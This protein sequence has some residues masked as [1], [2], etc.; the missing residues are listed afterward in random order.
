MPEKPKAW[1]AWSS[2]K[3]SAW[4]L[5]VARQLGE[6][7]IVGMMTTLTDAYNRIAMHGVR[8]DLL[9]A[10]ANAA[11]L[12]LHRVWIPSPCSD[13][14]YEAAMLEALTLA[15]SQGV[16]HIIFGD[17]FLQDLRDYREQKLAQI[18]MKG[19]FPL[20]MRETKALAHE[21]IE[22]GLQAYLTCINTQHL[23]K[24]LAGHSFNTELLDKLPPEVDPCGENGEFHSFVWDGPMFSKPIHLQ[25]GE[26]VER[27]GYVFTDLL[28]QE[29][30]PVAADSIK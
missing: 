27:E 15:K 21:M 9:V 10:Q 4:A 29:H 8:E 22:G 14:V 11:G 30:S 13:E 26:K 12:P 17:L 23:P 16:S 28:A 5:H 6:L 2:G 25:V 24:E 20:W 3:D 18:E 7:E 19:Y 1:M